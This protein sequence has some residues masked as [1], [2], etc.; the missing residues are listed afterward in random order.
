M[1]LGL[2]ACLG[3]GTAHAQTQISAG[4]KAGPP[5]PPDVTTSTTQ[6]GLGQ[7]SCAQ[8]LDDRAIQVQRTVNDLNA[9][10]LATQSA[11]AIADIAGLAVEAAGA[12]IIA[13]EI[14]GIVA[15]AAAAGANLAG[16]GVAIAGQVSNKELTDLDEEAR[17][18][19]NCEQAFTGTSRSR[20]AAPTC[21][22]TPSSTTTLPWPVGS[23]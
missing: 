5:T 3:L 11:A 23:M 15:Q 9:G 1:L 10:L 12:I 16:L 13:A 17:G 14:P 7:A 19:P 4:P 2:T 8:Q 22:A 20:R 6:V 18:L 21:L